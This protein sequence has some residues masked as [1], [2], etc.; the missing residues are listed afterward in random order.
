MIIA[1]AAGA[2]ATWPLPPHSMAGAGI[3][4]AAA[5][6][7][8]TLVETGN[9]IALFGSSFGGAISLA[10][11]GMLSPKS[12]VTVAAPLY[13]DSIQ[14]PYVNDPENMAVVQKLNREK[15]FFDIREKIRGLSHVLVFH[16][17]NDR[18]VPF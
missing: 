17:D 15:L 16:G 5:N 10:M 4:K 2:P 14:E 8:R 7:I 11:A 18:I 12:I 6:C 13:S 9:D 3:L 1:D